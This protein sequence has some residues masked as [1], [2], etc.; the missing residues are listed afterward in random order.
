M[1]SKKIKTP[2]IGIC[3]TGMG[4]DVCRGCKRFAHEVIGWN[5]Y[6]EEER[7]LICKRLDSLLSQVVKTSVEVIN[8]E[9]LKVF[10]REQK[11]K[12]N[13]SD[14]AYC[15]VFTLLKKKAKQLQSLDAA[16]CRPNKSWR[17]KSL[18]ELYDAI[19]DDFFTLSNAHYERY[20]QR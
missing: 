2:C 11:V 13:E 15:L 20:F 6:S 8:P 16:G 10:M 19:D 1:P 4:G 12:F 7:A 5:G 18:T 14:D 17:E 3:S 9:R